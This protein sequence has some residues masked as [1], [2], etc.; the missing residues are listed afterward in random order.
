MNMKLELI[1]IQFEELCSQCNVIK[2]NCGTDM[3][4]KLDNPSYICSDCI[5]VKEVNLCQKM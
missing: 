2:Y 4:S 1:K 5:N 3:T